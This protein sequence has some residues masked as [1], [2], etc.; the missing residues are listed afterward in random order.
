MQRIGAIPFLDN[1]IERIKRVPPS[2]MLL[3]LLL[4][5]LPFQTPYT[6]WLKPIS[7][8]AFSESHLPSF[9]LE[10]KLEFYGTDLLLLFILYLGFRHL[11]KRWDWGGKLLLLFLGVAALSLVGREAWAYWR[12]GQLALPAIALFS[13]ARGGI[14]KR[15]FRI[16]CWILFCSSLFQV[17]IALS[18]FILQHDLGLKQLGEVRLSPEIS[19]VIS[20]KGSWLSGTFIRCSGTL[21]HPNVLGGYLGIA[22]LSSLFLIG[23]VKRGKALLGVG[24]ALQLLGIGLT[25]SRGALVGSVGAALF[26]CFLLLGRRGRT[27]AFSGSLLL[28]FTVGFLKGDLLFRG[29]DAVRVSFQKVSLAMAK[30]FPLLGHGYG[31]YVAAMPPYCTETVSDFPQRVHNIYLLLLAETGAIGLLAF[32]LLLAS[33][34]QRALQIEGQMEKAALLAF[35]AFILWFGGVDHYWLTIVQGRLLLLFDLF[36]LFGLT[37][38]ESQSSREQAFLS[39]PPL[40]SQ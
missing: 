16:C 31:R 14:G 9:F 24:G 20:L 10:R 37:A 15:V 17:G 19:A 5:F 1:A 11:S 26:F 7:K 33:A 3:Y 40:G 25:F 21:P 13:L 30:D 27:L 28:L 18:Q 34:F 39:S 23:K 36:F 35:S 32:L 22:F 12:W 2:E 8:W 4:F 29:S 6:Q 38:P